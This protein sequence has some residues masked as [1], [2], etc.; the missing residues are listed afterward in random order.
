[1]IFILNSFNIFFYLNIYYF[2]LQYIFYYFFNYLYTCLRTL[3]HSLSTL[4]PQVIHILF[5]QMWINGQNFS[6]KLSKA[7]KF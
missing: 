3:I 1:M 2:N 7:F 4:Y 6:K 5:H